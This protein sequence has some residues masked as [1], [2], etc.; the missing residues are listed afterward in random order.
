MYFPGVLSPTYVT[1]SSTRRTPHPV[2]CSCLMRP[3]GPCGWPCTT[4]MAPV[5]FRSGGLGCLFVSLS[6]V[7]VR[8]EGMPLKYPD[9]C[10]FFL[11]RPR[12]PAVIL[13]WSASID[14]LCRRRVSSASGQ[15]RLSAQSARQGF[16]KR[17]V[18]FPW[19]WRIPPPKQGGTGWPKFVI[20]E[21]AR[22]GGGAWWS[23]FALT[24]LPCVLL[25]VWGEQNYL[26]LFSF[27]CL[28][29]HVIER[30]GWEL[31]T[32]RRWASNPQYWWSYGTLNF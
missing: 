11:S 10:F 7:G 26:Y 2:L 15:A 19:W 4:G 5:P 25:S 32:V 8:S 13:Q 30:H 1:I 23:G 27:L 18:V 16:E 24:E 31:S 22:V 9:T 14:S 28:I 21:G 12:R 17:G 3:I 20:M 6:V 29:W